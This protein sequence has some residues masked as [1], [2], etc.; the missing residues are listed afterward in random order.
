[1]YVF[2]K[3]K[4]CLCGFVWFCLFG[5]VFFFSCDRIIIGVGVLRRISDKG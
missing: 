5:I 2:F 3:L 1:M 4:L